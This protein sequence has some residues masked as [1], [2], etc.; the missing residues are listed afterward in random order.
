MVEIV[1]NIDEEKVIEMANK[2]ILAVGELV[3]KDEMPHECT[4]M[5][6]KLAALVGMEQLTDTFKRLPAKYRIDELKISYLQ[7]V[8]QCSE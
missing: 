2:I 8:K 7:F 5:E 1:R 3:E 4:P 6:L